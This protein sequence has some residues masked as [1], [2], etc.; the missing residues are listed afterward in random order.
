MSGSHVQKQDYKFAM[1]NQQISIWRPKYS[2]PN[3]VQVP[4]HYELCVTYFIRSFLPF[5]NCREFPLF[6]RAKNNILSTIRSPA[7]HQLVDGLSLK[8]NQ[9]RLTHTCRK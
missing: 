9:V 7:E 1:E 4:I 8:A 5:A 6:S 3:T 2:A